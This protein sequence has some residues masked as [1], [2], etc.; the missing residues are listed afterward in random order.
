ML[1]AVR[2]ELRYRK[3]VYPSLVRQEKMTQREANYQIAI[4]EELATFLHELN[5]PKLL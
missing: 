5:E 2:R 3:R 1:T 4:F